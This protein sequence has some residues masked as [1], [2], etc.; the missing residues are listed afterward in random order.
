MRTQN[1]AGGVNTEKI[2]SQQPK[3]K[4]VQTSADKIKAKSS[5]TH[6]SCQVQEILTAH[7]S[8]SSCRPNFKQTTKDK[9]I[10]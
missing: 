2:L 8:L 7:E 6:N 5:C 10:R 1:K 4:A 3:M 9:T